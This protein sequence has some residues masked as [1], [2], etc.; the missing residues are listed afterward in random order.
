LFKGTPRA[1]PDSRDPQESLA[2][3]DKARRLRDSIGGKVVELHPVVVAQPLL[4]RLAGA[5]KPR[6]CRWSKLTT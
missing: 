2:D 4:K 6:S 5:L 1:V 3:G